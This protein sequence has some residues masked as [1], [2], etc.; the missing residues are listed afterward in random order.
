[1][2][3]NSSSGGS[4]ATT[5]SGKRTPSN[6]PPTQPIVAA[7]FATKCNIAVRNHVPVLPQWKDYKKQPGI[8]KNFI[9]KVG[10]STNAL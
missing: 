9:G 7:K 2:K 6:A 5:R 8:F 3:K 1:M 4:F 10:V